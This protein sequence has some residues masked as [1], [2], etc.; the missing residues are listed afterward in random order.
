MGYVADHQI[1]RFGAVCLGVGDDL[2]R[3]VGTE[4][5]RH[6]VGMVSLR[7]LRSPPG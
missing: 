3:L 5:H 2:Q 4:H 1:K 7:A 6:L